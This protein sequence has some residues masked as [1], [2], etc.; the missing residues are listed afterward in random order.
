VISDVAVDVGDNGAAIRWTTNVPADG[1]ARVQIAPGVVDYRW[2]AETGWRKPVAGAGLSLTPALTHE[3]TVG[4]LEPGITYYFHVASMDQFGRAVVSPQASFQTAGGSLINQ[5]RQMLGQIYRS[6]SCSMR[7]NLPLI[8][9]AI[10]LA[11]V[12]GAVLGI[13]FWRRKRADARRAQTPT[14]A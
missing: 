12:A 4:N 6:M 11:I 5:A 10:G 7:D 3:V 13:L 1:Q 14:R 8:V 9:G 2:S